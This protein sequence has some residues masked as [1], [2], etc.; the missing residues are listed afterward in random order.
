MFILGV[1]HTE[2]V[3]HLHISTLLK[4]LFPYRS[5][6]SMHCRV[7]LHSRSS[8][9]VCFIY[10]STWMSVPIFPLI[11]PPSCLYFLAVFI[12]SYKEVGGPCFTDGS[13]LPSTLKCLGFTSLSKCR[14]TRVIE[15]T[16]WS[17]LP[18]HPLAKFSW[19]FGI[20]SKAALGL[21]RAW[22]K[23][24]GTGS[25]SNGSLP[26]LRWGRQGIMGFGGLPGLGSWWWMQRIGLRSFIRQILRQAGT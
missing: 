19:I 24:N 11:C 16:D 23:Q 18:Q 1:Q 10:S 25:R 4:I 12:M 2:S 8:L 22:R 7:L 13:I 17:S 5:L 6:Q 26:P 9:A 3:I 15:M 14:A 21:A 20:I